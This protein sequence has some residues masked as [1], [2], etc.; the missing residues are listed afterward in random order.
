MRE[1][2]RLIYIRLS[3]NQTLTLFTIFNVWLCTTNIKFM[4]ELNELEAVFTRSQLPDLELCM[5]S[6]VALLAS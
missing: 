2:S 6:H 5:K 3:G 1:K 4:Q